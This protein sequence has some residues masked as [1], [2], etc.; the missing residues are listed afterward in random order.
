[1]NGPNVT[2]EPV[3]LEGFGPQDL[4][5]KREKIFTRFFGGFLQRLR[6]FTGHLQKMRRGLDTTVDSFNRAIGSIESR[7]L[8]SARKFK[9]LGAASGDDIE[10][11]EPIDR[12][13][14]T[15]LAADEEAGEGPGAV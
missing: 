7:V 13:P 12:R 1:M 14:R 10:A 2:E 4:Y 11:V 6:V 15:P 3:K 8:V 9:T 5:Q